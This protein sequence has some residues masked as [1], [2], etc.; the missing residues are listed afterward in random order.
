MSWRG[1]AI[2]LL[3]AAILSASCMVTTAVAIRYHERT[4]A[5]GM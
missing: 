3:K 2:N 4:T 1:A 5:F